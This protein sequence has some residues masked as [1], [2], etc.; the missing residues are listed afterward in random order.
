MP[1]AFAVG[2]IVGGRGACRL[3]RGAIL[4]R[5]AME[6]ALDPTLVLGGMA[7]DR[8]EDEQGKGEEETAGSPGHEGK[9][10]RRRKEAREMG[11]PYEGGF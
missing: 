10:V 4:A 5:V 9:V 8:A 6:D 11:C 1:M 7:E 2:V 3:G